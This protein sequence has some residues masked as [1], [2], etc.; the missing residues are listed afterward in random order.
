MSPYDEGYYLGRAHAQPGT[1]LDPR[2]SFADHAKA[3]TFDEFKRG[4]DAGYESIITN[5][6][7]TP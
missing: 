3:G 2:W 6:E 5:K 7:N 1:D 4:F